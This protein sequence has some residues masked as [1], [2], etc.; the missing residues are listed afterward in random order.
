MDKTTLR[1]ITVIKNGEVKHIG[2]SKH[3]QTT[4]SQVWRRINKMV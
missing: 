1:F 4:G 2:K 3:Y